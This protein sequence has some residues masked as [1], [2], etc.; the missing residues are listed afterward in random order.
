MT[1]AIY[2]A[3]LNPVTNS[4]IEII[5]EL[6]KDNKVVVMPVRFLK[7]EN[8]VNSRS[9][10]FNFETRKK[11]LESVFGNSITV[12][13]NYSFQA[14]FKKYFPPLIS[15]KSWSLRKQILQGI[16]S[17]YFTYTGDKAEGLML[18]LYRL[19]PKIGVRKSVSATDVKNKMYEV[20]KGNESEWEKYMPE[21]IVQIINENW[22]TVRK[23]ASTEDMTKRIAGMK[24]PKEGYDS[25]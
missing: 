4:H 17:D 22:E 1:T 25:K 16:E 23:F 11:M 20:A 18:K 13:L 5:E 9:F 12:S 15:L 3:H 10:P 7:Q 6:K 21:G 24:F 19:N 14:P 2:L 8:E